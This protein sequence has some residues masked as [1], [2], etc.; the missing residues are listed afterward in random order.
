MSS[1]S[2]IDLTSLDFDDLKQSFKRYL[3]SQEIFKDYDYDGAN[4]NLLLEL[5]SYNTYK[6]AF[7]VNMLMAESFLDSAQLRNSVTSHAKELNYL[8]RSSRSA[9][10]KIKVSFEATS[11]NAPYIIEKGKPFSTIIKNTSYVFTNPEKIILTSTNTSFSFTTDIFEGT[12]L[13][14]SYTYLSGIENQ[15]FRLTNPNVD[16]RSLEV[17]VYEDNKRVGDVYKFSSTFLDVKYNSKVFFVQPTEDGKYE[18]FFGDNNIGRKPKD[19][20]IITLE[21]RTSS[22]SPPNGAKRFSCDFDPTGHDEI[23]SDITVD[24]IE[25]AR[26]G[27]EPESIDSIKYFAPRHFQV[28]ERTITESDYEISLKTKFPEINAVY[29]YGGETLDPPLFGRVMIA[30]DI[31]NVSSF[32]EIK[33]KEYYDFIKKRS[34]F[35]IEPVF[36][37]PEYSFLSIFTKVRFNINVTANTKETIKTQVLDSI[38]AYSNEHL[39]DFSVILRY[40]KLSSLI[41]NSDPSIISSLTKIAIYKKIKPKLGEKQKMVLNYNIKLK[42]DVPE[43]QKINKLSDVK[44]LYSSVFQVSGEQCMLEDDGNGKI[45]LMKIVKDRNERISEVGTLDYITGQIELYNFQVD[46]YYGKFI[47]I[48]VIPDDPDVKVTQNTI[49]LLDNDEINIEIEEL[50][51]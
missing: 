9:K 17:I 42:D 43:K 35:T 23:Q 20:S 5:M 7:L 13:K 3:Q 50:R 25:N 21:Y 40:S 14:D 31:S 47:K 34:P 15:K 28:Q 38:Q 6:N 41:D 4:M 18:I 1:N 51:I 2:S 11:E 16:L 26:D 29:A 39:N 48:F 8:P 24:L 33:K 10:A 44:T 49:L 45:Y 37:E 36:V 19:N 30:V 22:G 12:Y 32:P 46:F 27:S